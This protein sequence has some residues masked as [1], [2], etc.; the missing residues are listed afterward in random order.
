MTKVVVAGVVRVPVATELTYW[1]PVA[2]AT[3]VWVVQAKVPS[4]TPVKVIT[5]V[6][7]E[8][9][10]PFRVAAHSCPGGR[11]VATNSTVLLSAATEGMVKAKIAIEAKSIKPNVRVIFVIFILKSPH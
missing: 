9:G 7:E 2:P 1:T 6:Y 4:A 11:P 8:L 3:G 10:T 5:L